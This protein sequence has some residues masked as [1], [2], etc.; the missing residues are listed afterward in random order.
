MAISYFAGVEPDRLAIISPFGNRTFAELNGRANQLVA[1]LAERG[2]EPGDPVALLCTN[3][4][5]FAEVYAAVHR[6]GLRITTINWH[7]TG[8]EAGYI[9]D[10][11]EAKA[12]IAD[13]RVAE[14]ARTAAAAA[15][16]ATVRLAIGG[17][18]DGV[19][20]YEKALAGQPAQDPAE[21]RLGSSMLYTSGTTGRP[22]GVH[23]PTPPPVQTGALNIYGYQPTG[24]VHLCTG[25]LYH[26]APLAFSLASPLTFGVPVV[27]MDTWDA[28]ETLAM[29]A[30]HKVTHSHLV[31]TMFHRLLALPEDVKS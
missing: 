30:E 9:V 19:E 13:S 31:P 25:P 26:A 21:P 12:F 5:E 3:R 10:D 8:E 1:A 15:P 27:L 6:Y 28:E 11:C 4:P 17:P 14:G 29:V 22:K 16:K 23:R 7:L 20:E 24:D 2:I 18:I